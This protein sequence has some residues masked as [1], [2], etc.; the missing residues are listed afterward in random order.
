MD[1]VIAYKPCEKDIYEITFNITYFGY[2]ALA[3]LGQKNKRKDMK[4]KEK[5][6]RKENNA[7]YLVQQYLL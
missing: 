7:V 5:K 3:N 1:D 4:R 2:Y 6:K